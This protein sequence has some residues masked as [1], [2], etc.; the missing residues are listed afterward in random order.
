MKL[1]LINLLLSLSLV[2]L[3]VSSSSSSSPEISKFK[4]I[5]RRVLRECLDVNP[6]ISINVSKSSMLPDEGNIT[7]T[8]SGVVDPDKDDWIAM[9]SPSNLDVSDCP[10]NA[11]MYAQTGDLSSLPL[12]C[13]YP[14][15]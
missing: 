14:V 6:Y 3:A 8:V 1:S 7:V 4:V 2:F 13:H 15:K 11:A 5:N 10:L 12:L 9:I